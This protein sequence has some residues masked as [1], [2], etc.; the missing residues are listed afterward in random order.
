MFYVRYGVMDSS[1][2]NHGT[3]YYVSIAL[4]F[5]AGSEEGGHRFET[6]ITTLFFFRAV[7][8]VSHSK[9]NFLI[10]F[11]TSS[12]IAFLYH[13]RSI[14]N[15][16]FNNELQL[17]LDYKILIKQHQRCKSFLFCEKQ[18]SAEKIRDCYQLRLIFFSYLGRYSSQ[19]RRK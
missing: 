15:K 7:I 1:C 16:C 4:M 11:K 9:F 14:L 3:D 13:S 19:A 17:I 18:I 6:I 10:S 12:K 8:R 2:R 5:S